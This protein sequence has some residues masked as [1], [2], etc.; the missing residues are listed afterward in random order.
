MS[1][2]AAVL[3][4]LLLAVPA[5]RAFA[6][7]KKAAGSTQT[8]QKSSTS[9]ES[10]S[11]ETPPAQAKPAEAPPSDAPVKQTEEP[12]MDFDLLEPSTSAESPRLIDPEMEAAIARRR[13]MLTIHQVTGLTMAAT[14]AATVIVG[15]L[16]F[17]DVY[18]GGGDTGRYKG[19]HTGLA[20]ASTTLFAGTA[21]LGLLAPTPFKKEL[22]LD[23]ITLHKVFMSLATAGMLTQIVLGLVTASQE[24]KLS[25]V[26]LA[27]AH[28]VIGYATLGAVS[29]GAL[30]IVF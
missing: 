23:T 11:S 20:I 2:T 1:R 10:K 15:Q 24:G 9:S 12:S 17:N 18:R 19:W 14:L 27:T 13:T 8:S 3:L 4:V 21:M 22:R 30:M 29:A 6:A 7:G 16:N 26:D 25:Q 5:P 28:Q